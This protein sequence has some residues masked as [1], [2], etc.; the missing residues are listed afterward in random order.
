[1]T[2]SPGDMV[3]ILGTLSDSELGTYA[4][5]QAMRHILQSREQET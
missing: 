5:H 4:M 1:M 3:T 2:D